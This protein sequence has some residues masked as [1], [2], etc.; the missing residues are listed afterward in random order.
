MTL[1]LSRGE[2]WL[3]ANAV[4]HGL[5]L[6]LLT[7]PEWVPGGTNNAIDVVLNR[8][9]HGL[10]F[11]SLLET[12]AQMAR[13]DWIR[14]GRT[15][16]DD[17]ISCPDTKEIDVFLR[18]RVRF[19]QAVFYWLTAAGGAAWEAFARPEWR[20]YIEHNHDYAD[21]AASCAR[22][23]TIET[24]NWKQLDKYLR[25]LAGEQVI[26][27]GSIVLSEL[28]PWQATYWKTLPFGLRCTFRSNETRSRDYLT[29]PQ[30]MRE[31]WCEWR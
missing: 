23:T 21:D 13:N 29:G 3:L 7:M 27:A 19:D 26:E 25:A 4:E 15:F 2:F 9:G 30:R 24:S 18:E 11:E 16:R 8:Q 10:G 1:R 5:P 28:R 20:R 31:A 22:M 12:L 14:F 6:P 17:P